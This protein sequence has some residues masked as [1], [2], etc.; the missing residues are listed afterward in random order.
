MPCS[1]A[2]GGETGGVGTKHPQKYKISKIYID[3]VTSLLL[4]IVK[5]VVPTQ[6]HLDM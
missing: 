4:L 5:T 2:V 1:R 3:F 6:I